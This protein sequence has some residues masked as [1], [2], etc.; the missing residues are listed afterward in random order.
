MTTQSDIDILARQIDDGWTGELPTL[1]LVQFEQLLGYLPAMSEDKEHRFHTFVERIF[2]QAYKSEIYLRS[3]PK[4]GKPSTLIARE[5]RTISDAIETA[6]AVLE[7]A[8]PAARDFI[9]NGEDFR[10]SSYKEGQPLHLDNVRDGLADFGIKIAVVAS[11]SDPGV[12]RGRSDP[13]FRRTVMSLA[14]F[15]EEVTGA[16]PKR[17]YFPGDKDHEGRET[18]TLLDM[19]QAV[20]A[21]V[22][23]ALPE[24]LRRVHPMRMSG[25]VRTVLEQA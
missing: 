4:D 16:R 3:R 9:E 22:N 6:V 20:S 1:S 14:A 10:L 15:Y 13:G 11:E 25:I 18:G 17:S 5:L 23:E 2:Q 7:D 21:F 19:A 24:N 8:S 12:K